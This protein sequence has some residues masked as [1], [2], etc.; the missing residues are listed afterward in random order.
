M[1]LFRMIQR[2]K[3]SL[4]NDV[5]SK[6]FNRALPPLGRTDYEEID[7]SIPGECPADILCSEEEVGQM[8]LSLDTTKSSGSDGISAI[9]LKE[10][11]F[12]ITPGITK[13]FNTSI[14]TGSYHS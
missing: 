12:S 6:C 7:L 5:F 14:R 2:I 13:L 9:M 10:T 11:A 8:L 4:L 1:I 3:A